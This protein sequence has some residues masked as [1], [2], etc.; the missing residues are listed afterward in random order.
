MTCCGL[1]ASV[2]RQQK[3]WSGA[4]AVVVLDHKAHVRLTVG[5]NYEDSLGRQKRFH[6][7]LVCRAATVAWYQRSIRY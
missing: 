3:G 2:G 7:R 4:V 1:R 6:G 5:S